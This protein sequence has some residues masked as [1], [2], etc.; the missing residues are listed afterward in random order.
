MFLKF[1]ILFSLLFIV[2]KVQS[3]KIDTSDNYGVDIS[4]PIH[5]GISPD[6][7]FGRRYAEH[8]RGCYHLY[9]QR[10][11]DVTERVRLEM[12][13]DQPTT[14]CNYSDFGFKK[15][16]TPDSIWKPLREFYQKY[17]NQQELES[18]PHGYTYVNNWNSPTYM[19]SLE[20]PK[21]P[22]GERLKKQVWDGAR[23]IL[24]EWSGQSLMETSL[25]GIRVYTNNSIL[26][27][28]VDR[29][30]LVSSAIINVDQDVDEPWF[31]ELY[32][33]D[34]KA[35]NISMNVGDMVLYESHSTLH[36]RPFPMK[37]RFYA[38]LFVHFSPISH[39]DNNNLSQEDKLALASHSLKLDPGTSSQTV[40]DK[41]V[42]FF[43]KMKNLRGNAGHEQINHDDAP[44]KK[45][46][47]DV[48]TEE[49]QRDIPKGRT[50]LH[51]A[52]ANGDFSMIKRMINNHSTDILHAR[53]EN[54][55][56]AIH[57]AARGGFS[58]IFVHF[59]ELGADF[60]AAT[61]AGV[62]FIIDFLLF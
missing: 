7:Y 23:S 17:K 38:N 55:W 32:G 14:Q 11:C 60:N 12:N 33:R 56:Q 1:I 48:L 40:S 27:T 58:D 43:E 10:S 29:L 21:F 46:L 6:T 51:V 54:G 15:I 42:G 25:Y 8:M 4:Y 62:S 20:N 36:G 37:G 41:L 2:V 19:I 35:Y 50:D 57:E 13:R 28:H 31:A 53:D 24:E 3:E 61:N 22:E 44:F 9:D 52:A 39:D 34:G 45:H 30:P 18:W 16:K 5:W 49:K 59:V 26:A 47:G